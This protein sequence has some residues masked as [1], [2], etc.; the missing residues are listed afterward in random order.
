MTDKQGQ[1]SEEAMTNKIS[2]TTYVELPGNVLREMPRPEDDRQEGY[3]DAFDASSLFYD[4]FR[5]GSRI[6]LSGPPLANLANTI[7]KAK[8]SID[9]TI[10]HP[11]LQDKW[12]TQRSYINGFPKGAKL[13]IDS[14]LV[15]GD[16]DIQPDEN[17]IFEGKRVLYTLSKNNKLEWIR[18][19]A[20]FYVK[21]HGIN[22]ILFY[23]NASDNYNTKDILETI[24]GVQ[25]ID[26]VVVVEWPYKY[27]P[28]CGP[29]GRWDSDYCQYSTIEHAR[30]RFLAYCRGVINADIDEL[31]VCE[32][33]GTIFEYLEKSSVGAVTYTGL[34][35]EAV[36]DTP[37]PLHR[38]FR[39]FRTN[40]AAAT[41]KWTLTPSAI[42]DDI[43]INVHSLGSGFEAQL[44]NDVRHRHFSAINY[45]WK[46]KR[47]DP[48]PYNSERH[49]VDEAYVRVMR[50]IG[51][52]Y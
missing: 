45:N 32:S 33:G 10:V 17:R 42:P 36:G 41:K 50:E 8:F 5:Y 47:A 28:G 48:T 44:L 24:R 3:V 39:Y 7:Q 6:V 12:K 49:A 18:D 38:H 23:D 21:A 22:G 19:W 40:R 37:D 15:S 1:S 43:Q 2:T 9:G 13:K 52:T 30:R 29:S 16:Y 11:H 46:K 20:E 25:G 14:D 35:L 51:W 34:W 27:G 4:I 31:I 26:A